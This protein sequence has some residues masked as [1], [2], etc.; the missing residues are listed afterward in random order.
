VSLVLCLLLFC[1][2]L[3][4]AG[5]CW[6][7]CIR[8]AMEVE[9]FIDESFTPYPS[10]NIDGISLHSSCFSSYLEIRIPRVVKAAPSLVSQLLPDMVNG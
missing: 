3:L 6:C 8:M 5:D 9:V 1:F 10:T 4:F 7:T 2:V